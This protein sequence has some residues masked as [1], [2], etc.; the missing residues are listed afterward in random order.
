MNANQK[1]S[2]IFEEWLSEAILIKASRCKKETEEIFSNVVMFDAKLEFI[3]GA[4]PQ[5][6]SLKINL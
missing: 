2:E 5:E 6:Y 1:V 3:D 4:T